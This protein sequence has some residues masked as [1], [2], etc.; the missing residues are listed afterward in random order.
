VDA[1]GPSS[2]L[3]NFSADQVQQRQQ[4]LPLEEF[5]AAQ[6]VRLLE[7]QAYS[8]AASLVAS[9]L[10]ESGSPNDLL[11]LAIYL[12]DE[13]FDFER[14]RGASEAEYR[15]LWAERTRQLEATQDAAQVLI[16]SLG[17]ALDSRL[18]LSNIV[19][20]K[21]PAA[22]L[23]VVLR[24]TGVL[25]VALDAPVVAAADGIE[26]RYALA[27]N[28]DGLQSWG[29]DG[30]RGSN[31]NCGLSRFSTACRSSSVVTRPAPSPT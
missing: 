2:L 30:N 15:A 27:M 9:R 16:E 1:C 21:V 22:A 11:D 29:W 25:G 6:E 20:G 31:A 10:V 12:P 19:Y 4:A 26:R 14:L 7:L 13:F 3:A 24:T 28:A 18:Q 17:G 23:A 8:S 5:R